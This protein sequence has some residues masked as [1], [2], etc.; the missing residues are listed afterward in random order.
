MCKGYQ[1]ISFSP[2][3]D[4][5]TRKNKVSA[6]LVIKASASSI[7]NLKATLISK[8]YNIT[9]KFK[10]NGKKN[11]YV[12]LANHSFL[13]SFISNITPLR[14]HHMES[15]EN[16]FGSSPGV[17]RYVCGKKVADKQSLVLQT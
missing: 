7:N 8:G 14:K 16:L 12:D 15:S 17:G 6:E 2:Q 4:N 3:Q 13:N 1:I 11:N 5:I 9:E 10:S